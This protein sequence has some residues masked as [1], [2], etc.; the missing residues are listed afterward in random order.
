M[1]SKQP[2]FDGTA[3]PL[4]HSL[5]PFWIQLITLIPAPLAWRCVAKSSGS[6]AQPK[7]ARYRTLTWLSPPPSDSPR[8]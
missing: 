5:K 1:Q 4:W 7:V 8:T 2:A 3:K 6:G